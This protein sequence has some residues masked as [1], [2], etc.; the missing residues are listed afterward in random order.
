MKK[1]MKKIFKE[2]KLLFITA[3]LYAIAAFYHFPT[4]VEALNN[5]WI[6]LKEMLEILPAVFILTGLL[7]TWVP[8]EV[9]MKNFG[10]ESGLKGK[11]ISLF[12]GSVSA[13]PIYAAFPLVNSLLLKGASIAN[14]V[15]I[16]SAWAVVKIPMLL[17]ESKFL[18]ISFALSRYVLTVPG[19]ILMGIVCER[20]ISRQNLTEESGEKETEEAE[21]MEKIFEVLPGYNCGSCGYSSCAGYA[22]AI[23]ARKESP[24]KCVPGLEKV[25][26]EI[27]ELVQAGY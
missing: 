26:I 14:S 1:L 12:I 3:V 21:L 13:G 2:Y 23:S 4:F 24:D 27:K 8:A 6:Y 7:N 17:V 25:E 20:L 22:R 15:I 16:I 5:S 10:K 11:I 19:I 9:I 18:G